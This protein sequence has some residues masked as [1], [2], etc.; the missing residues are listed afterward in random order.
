MPSI[1]RS[2]T[3]R[4]VAVGAAVAGVLLATPAPSSAAQGPGPAGEPVPLS[5]VAAIAYAQ[6]VAGGATSSDTAVANQLRGQMNG[7]RVGTSLNGYHVSCARAISATAA[8]RGLDKRAAVIAITTAITESSLHNYTE[9][10]DHDSL[11]LFQQRPSQ[12]WGSPAQLTDPVYATNAFLNAMIRKY[13]DNSWMS[14]DIGA[15]CQRVQVS[16]FPDAYRPEVHD[17]QLLANALWSGGGGGGSGASR[18]WVDTYANAPVFA[19]ATSTTQTG[20]LNQGTNYVY[21]KVWGRQISGGSSYNHYWL[22]TD[23]DTGPAGQYVSAYYLSRWGNDE[24][25]DNSGV[26]IPDCAGGARPKY[27]VDTYANAP[28]Y[29]S[30]TSTTQT[31]TLNQGTNYVYC[32]V[33]GRQIGSGSS[34]NHY[35]LKTDPDAG[36]ADQFVSA[37]YLSRWGNDEAKDNNGTV[38]PNC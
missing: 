18:Y 26:V 22:K 14:G 36:P 7:N 29:A 17:A 13:P 5:Q 11:G 27:W 9:A 23:P 20:T 15:I 32:K 10:V 37:Y 4:L 33:W 3:P 25:K 35:W 2:W 28:V 6:C 16:A 31:G 38:I 19:S 8:G 21:C 12:G 30:A 34:Y 1:F 24:A